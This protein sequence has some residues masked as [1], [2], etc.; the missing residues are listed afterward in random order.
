MIEPN[1]YYFEVLKHKVLRP[2]ILFCNALLSDSTVPVYFK[3]DGTNSSVVL[4]NDEKSV[5]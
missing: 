1:E 4:F 2:G 5:V 3:K